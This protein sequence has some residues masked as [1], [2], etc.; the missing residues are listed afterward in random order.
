MVDVLKSVEGENNG[1]AAMVPGGEAV[2]PH[3]VSPL[4][5]LH[6][7]QAA[8][9]KNSITEFPAFTDGETTRARIG[10]KDALVS[11]CSWT[12]PGLFRGRPMSGRRVTLLSGH[13][14]V[15]VVTDLSRDAA[16]S[17][18]GLRSDAKLPGDRRDGRRT[19]TRCRACGHN[20]F[21]DDVCEGCRRSLPDGAPASDESARPRLTM[22][23]GREPTRRVSLTGEVF[24]SAEAPAH[25]PYSE[26]GRRRPLRPSSASR[27]RTRKPKAIDLR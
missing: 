27:L 21:T 1:I 11:A 8:H 12:A 18:A 10:G 4:A 13:H 15:S 14:E 6:S 23:T 16:G 24:E 17:P 20:S 26:R 9:L 25:K 19:V 5:H 3:E 22:T 2:N 7:T